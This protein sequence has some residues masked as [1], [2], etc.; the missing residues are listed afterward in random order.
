MTLHVGKETLAGRA[1]LVDIN[2]GDPV[3]RAGHSGETGR[4]R[5]AQRHLLARAQAHA[6]VVRHH[7]AALDLFR[8]I[9]RK[10]CYAKGGV[11]RLPSC[12]YSGHDRPPLRWGRG[13]GAC[14]SS[15]VLASSTSHKF[16]RPNFDAPPVC[17]WGRCSLYWPARCGFRGSSV[18]I[19]G[20][21]LYLCAVACAR[22]A[23]TACAN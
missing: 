10:C 4:I 5:E 3:A 11:F 18:R 1:R 19:F 22:S 13:S 17:R 6:V 12:K 16:D 8:R 14:N 23:A 21:R 2:D 9:E 7:R 15:D 20:R